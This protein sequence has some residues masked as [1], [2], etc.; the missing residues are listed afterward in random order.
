MCVGLGEHRDT[1]WLL[2]THAGGRHS[3]WLDTSGDD[4]S[5]GQVYTDAG[6]EIGEINQKDDRTFYAKT[7]M[8]V[9]EILSD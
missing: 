4:N 8:S 5:R 1:G 2:R 7:E 6:K 3:S 9:G